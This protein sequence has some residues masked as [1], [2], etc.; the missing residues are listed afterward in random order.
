MA[1]VYFKR[2]HQAALDAM[3]SWVE[4][5]FYL[6]DDTNRLYFAQA[7]N[8]L[9]DLNQYIHFVATRS[10][11]PTTAGS[12]LKDGDIYYIQSENI[13]CIYQVNENPPW[14]QI[15]PDT[16]LDDGQTDIVSV[17]TDTDGAYIRTS[18]VDT[19]QTEASGGFSI[20]GGTNVTVTPNASTKTITIAATDTNDNTTYTIGVD[21]NSSN[22]NVQVNLTAST[23]VAADNSSI[24]LVGSGNVNVSR[25]ASDGAVLIAGGSDV[26]SISDEFDNQGVYTISLGGVDLSTSGV[27]P[28]IQYGVAVGEKEN[29]HFES[30]TAVL[31]IY[32]KDEIDDMF[33]A[34][35][36]HIE[37]LQYAG[38]VSS[39]TDAQSKIKTNPKYGVGTVYKASADFVLTNPNLGQIRTGDLLIAKSDTNDDNA[40]TWELIP[41]GNDQNIQMQGGAAE[42]I[43][44]F[45][46]GL[47][48]HS[49]LGSITIN[50][51]RKE[52]VDA[53]AT[54]ANAAIEVV[55]EVS[56]DETDTT[57][58]I[59]H[60]A[61]GTGTAVSAAGT[62]TQTTGTALTIPVITGITKDAQGHITA[63]TKQN[64]TL[65]DTHAELQEISKSIEA[66]SNE[67]TA[68]FTF[69]LDAQDTQSTSVTM[70]SNT[71]KITTEAV[72]SGSSADTHI[73]VDLE[74][75]TF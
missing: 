70:K 53:T 74:W 65:T 72:G 18:V 25:R 68:S 30:G 66:V 32:T 4:G 6:T 41:S 7:N 14:V 46:D 69:Q 55:T 48:G 21:P 9:V 71:L 39:A 28:T 38:S 31:D 17:D 59:V 19:R 52:G 60:G 24:T 75:G 73:V 20:V 8:K 5:S 13:L 26:T 64:Y 1:N 10:N 33:V 67:V 44:L 22:N 16:R 54:A 61:P 51:G 23:N 2:G 15:N 62:T 56:Q 35:V 42:N 63:V 29:V 58:T 27:Q 3:Q 47:A 57:F 11:L 50:G 34:Q 43:V 12:T 45:K 37:A 40:C 49:D 36:E